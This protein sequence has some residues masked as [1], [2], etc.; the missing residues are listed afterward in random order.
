MRSLFRDQRGVTLTELM[1]AAVIFMFIATAFGS[2]YVSSIRAIDRG[3]AEVFVQQ[4]GTLLQEEIARQLRPAV[5][6]AFASSGNTCAAVAAPQA[7]AFQITPAA[8]ARDYF[9]GISLSA[10]RC[11]YQKA[12]TIDVATDPFPQLYVCYLAAPA[13]GL[14]SDVLGGSGSCVTNTKRNLLRTELDPARFRQGVQMAAS[15][16]AQLRVTNTS[17]SR[18]TMIGSV[19][20]AALSIS[21]RLDLT[22]GSLLTSQFESGTTAISGLRFGFNVVLRN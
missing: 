21:V 10:F 14:I 16:P 11:I 18:V 3:S 22:D 6:M 20:A 9:A 1:L 15:G 12:E 13:S 4:Q 19:P 17:F 8:A 5:T 7:M 2:L